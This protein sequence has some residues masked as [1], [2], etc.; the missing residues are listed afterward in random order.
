MCAATLRKGRYVLVL[1]V[2]TLLFFVLSVTV[3][4]AEMITIDLF[5]DPQDPDLNLLLC[6]GE[7]PHEYGNPCAMENLFLKILRGERDVF[8]EA[9]G[10]PT[11]IS[12]SA[13]AGYEPSYQ[14]G[15]LAFATYG[16][17]NIGSASY[18]VLQYD[19]EDNDAGQPTWPRLTNSEQLN[20]DLTDGGTNNAFVFG[21]L[22]LDAGSDRT[23]LDLK[24]KVNGLNGSAVYAGTIPES[25]FTF[26]HKVD[27]ADFTITGADPFDAATSVE[28]TFND[29]T[30]P[31]MNVD[32]ELD[33]ISAVPEPATLAM[34][35]LGCL[36]Y[37]IGARIWRLRRR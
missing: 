23:S 35:A 1:G 2:C 10:E 8:V 21:F 34:L 11:P 36:G 18:L 12:A 6:P 20:T 3:G 19:G 33:S 15:I 27:F 9:L 4:H 7:A 22:G 17:G 16:F 25:E 24:I 31:V 13:V 5:E 28:F 37:F 29:P 14:T 26:D 30:T 32:F